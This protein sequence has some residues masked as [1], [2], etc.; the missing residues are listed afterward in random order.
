MSVSASFQTLVLDQLGRIS[1]GVRARR[2]FG[3]VGIYADDLFFALIDDDTLYFKT[4]ESTRPAF[5]SLGMGP[6]RPFGEAGASMHYYQVPE[7]LLEDADELR[8]WVHEA[9]AVARRAKAKPTRR[10]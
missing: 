10:R 3:A 1:P 5:E 2:M 4:D 8:L 9:L 7:H 6:F